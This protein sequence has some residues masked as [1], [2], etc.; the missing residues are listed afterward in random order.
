[1]FVHEL[2]YQGK[3]DAVAIVDHQRRFTYHDLQMI[4]P[5]CR[6]RLFA[7]G[8][9]QG[10]RVGIFSRNSADFIFAYL[11]IASLGAIAVPIN[12]QLSSREVAFIVKDAGIQHI[13]TYK[14]LNLADAMAALR[15]DLKVVQHDIRLCSKIMLIF[16]LLQCWQLIFLRK[17][18]VS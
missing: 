18:L 6:N 8:I 7:M 14:P 16:L 5:N 10:D 2:I 4:V 17:I 9:R 11:A 13:F 15:C 12:F 3:A 1:M